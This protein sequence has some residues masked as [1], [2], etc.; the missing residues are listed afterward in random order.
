MWLQRQGQPWQL[1]PII[2]NM[3][4]FYY[5]DHIQPLRM[6]ACCVSWDACV[7]CMLV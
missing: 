4:C 1:T 7:L 2:A 3:L 6:H 5:H